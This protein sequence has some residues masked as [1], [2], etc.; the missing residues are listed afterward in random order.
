MGHASKADRIGE[1][2]QAL[3]YHD[4]EMLGDSVYIKDYDPGPL[5]DDNK[6]RTEAEIQRERH[7]QLHHG[8]S[9]DF[10]GIPELQDDWCLECTKQ[11]L[12]HFL[13]EKFC[14]DILTVFG[15]DGKTW[16]LF[17]RQN[18][19]F[20]AIETLRY[21]DERHDEGLKAATNAVKIREGLGPSDAERVE[22]LIEE[23]DQ[24]C[25]RVTDFYA[26]RMG[27]QFPR[28]ISR[29]EKLNALPAR[30]QVPERLQRY[31][32]EAT[33]CYVFG[34]F[35]GCVAICRGALEFALGEFLIR[36]GKQT[37]LDRL[38]QEKKDGLLARIELAKSA[39]SWKLKP[40]LDDAN[41]IRIRA[42][43]TIHPS[44]VDEKKLDADQCKALFF[45]TRGVLR[46][47]YS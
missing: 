33:R 12:A 22:R 11:F 15:A 23:W 35:F 4:F 32:V 41:E 20:I 39:G 16:K 42:N 17:D 28:M 38:D 27:D 45:K 43:I 3:A 46:E 34:Q 7:I 25:D 10:D 40:T 21:L 47:L 2:L 18:A 29:A 26:W 5:L 14:V 13:G 30:V 37:E 24:D 1:V 36:H 8:V 9:L 6:V 31:L 44:S 19:V